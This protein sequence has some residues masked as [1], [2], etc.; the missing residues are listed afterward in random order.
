MIRLSLGQMTCLVR[1]L[2][3]WLVPTILPR[4][5]DAT[6]LVIN[7]LDPFNR[8]A[9]DYSVVNHWSKTNLTLVWSNHLSLGQFTQLPISLKVNPK[10]KPS[11]TILR[12]HSPKPFYL[13][14][15]K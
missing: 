2:A 6:S 15:H 5:G 10:P 14:L 11:H 7:S 12:F 4:I 13:D 3:P 9:A 8:Y 1:L